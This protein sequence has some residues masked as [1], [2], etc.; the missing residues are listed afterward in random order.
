MINCICRL[1][2]Y[3]VILGLFGV[4]RKKSSEEKQKFNPFSIRFPFLF[5]LF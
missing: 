2:I 3:F 1:F 4:I 5:Q